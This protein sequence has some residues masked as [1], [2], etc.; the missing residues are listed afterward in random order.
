AG[1][2][3]RFIQS[4]GLRAFRR[5]LRAKELERYTAAFA[6]QA[7]SRGSFVEGAREV[8]E[9]MLQSPHFLFHLEGGP[10]GRSVDYA[11]ASRLSY[12]LLDTMP[13]PALFDA[14]AKGELRDP[15]GREKWARRILDNPLAHQSLDEFF[16]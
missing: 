14:A 13:T 16:N 15:A 9:A 6:A 4:F 8:V 11:I 10:D 7:A 12:L 2:R 1:C 3:D 5:P